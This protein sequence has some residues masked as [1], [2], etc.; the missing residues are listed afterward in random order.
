VKHIVQLTRGAVLFIL[1]GM[2]SIQAPCCLYAEDKPQPVKE[3]PVEQL[4][5]PAL[6]EDSQQQ[7]P[8]PLTVETDPDTPQ[9]VAVG[10]RCV[11]GVKTKARKVTWEIPTGVETIS[12][13]GKR[14]AVWGLPGTYVFTAMVPNGDDV[15]H[16]KITLT[17]SGGI[18]PPGPQPPAPTP[19]T[20]PAPADAYTAALQ[21]AYNRSVDSDK[22]DKLYRYI[23]FLDTVL[24]PPTGTS[25]LDTQTTTTSTQLLANLVAMRRAAGL[26]DGSLEGVGNI[27]EETLVRDVLKGEPGKPVQAFNLDTNSRAAF[28]TFF[29]KTYNALTKVQK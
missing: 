8:A 27:I 7:E 14:L 16:I 2:I 9:T 10:K 29:T 5:M 6:A 19:P 28:R 21:D 13:D 12:L 4:P 18:T 17:I 23:V 26:P 22:A 3:L 20:P 11:I 24:K 15:A 25:V 1:L